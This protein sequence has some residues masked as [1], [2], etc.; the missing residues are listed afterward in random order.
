MSYTSDYT[1]AEIDGGILKTTFITVTGNIDLDDVMTK[2]VYDPNSTAGDVFDSANIDYD[3]TTSGLSAT[4]VQGAIDEVDSDLDAHKAD[5]VTSGNP[6]G[7]DAKANKVQEDWIIPTLENG[8][9]TDGVSNGHCEYRKDNMG[10]VWVR[11]KIK[12][13]TV[14]NYTRIFTLPLGYKPKESIPAYG[15]DGNVNVIIKLYFN[16]SGLNLGA[17]SSAVSGSTYFIIAS[18]PAEK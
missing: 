8:W 3:G 15:I 13:G 4:D 14:S 5:D 18:F 2:T 7:I 12:A 6:H 10:N 17:S 9:T 11:A 1:G 16:T